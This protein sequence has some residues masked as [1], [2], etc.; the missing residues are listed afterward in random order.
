[1]NKS[2]IDWTRYLYIGRDLTHIF[3]TGSKLNRCPM[4]AKFIDLHTKDKTE[5][6]KIQKD[7]MAR[8]LSPSSADQ[9][10]AVGDLIETKFVIDQP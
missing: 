10:E 2:A 8:M 3:L 4:P 6:A 1:M 7:C 9:Y 5:A